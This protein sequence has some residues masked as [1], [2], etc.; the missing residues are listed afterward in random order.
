MKQIREEYFK[1]YNEDLCERIK[2][3]LSGDYKKIIVKLASKQLVNIII[4]KKKPK[5]LND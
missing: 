3:D 4:R 5:K 2:K 1:L